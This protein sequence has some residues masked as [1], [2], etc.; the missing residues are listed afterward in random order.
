MN[1]IAVGPRSINS[2]YFSDRIAGLD[3]ETSSEM[4]RALVNEGCLNSTGYLNDN[5][6]FVPYAIHCPM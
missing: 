6:R 5:P 1:Q 4:Y 3:N 2:T